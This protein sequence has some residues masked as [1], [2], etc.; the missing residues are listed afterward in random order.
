[1]QL[2]V[3]GPDT[4]LALSSGPDAVAH[5]IKAAEGQRNMQGADHAIKASE[6]LPC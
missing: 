1:M 3:K 4:V 6:F 2:P 5:Q